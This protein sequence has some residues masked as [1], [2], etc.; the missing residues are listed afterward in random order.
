MNDRK[1]H[2]IKT[3]L[4]LFIE[5]GYQATSIQDIL[6]D[7]GIS[8]GTFYNYFSSKGELA[9]AIF[10]S[11]HLNLNKQINDLLIGQDRSDIE[12]FI[13]QIELQMKMNRKN[14]L[15]ALVEEIFVSNDTDMKKFVKQ[16]QLIQLKWYYNRFI[17]LFGEEKKPYLL[18][19]AVIF[20]GILH[21][22][23]HFQLMASGSSRVEPVIR[24]SVNRI[25]TVVD[26]LAETGEQLLDPDLME[27]WVPGTMHNCS[28]LKNK[29]LE[30]IARLKSSIQK[31]IEIER[32]QSQYIEL[33]DF[34]QEE[35]VNSNTPRQFVIESALLTLKTMK[36]SSCQKELNRLEKTVCEYLSKV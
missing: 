29:L 6:D 19:C 36:D 31:G 17:D 5:K 8:K 34:I 11:L 9:K 35:A 1:Q 28:E 22:H 15:F 23:F 2:V 30:T 21:H 4:E 25:V 26:E 14:K 32:E 33:L 18:D 13:K 27:K 3:A 7:S 16:V 12:I 20:L 10:K 24:Y